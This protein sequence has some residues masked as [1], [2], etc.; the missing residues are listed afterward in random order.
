MLKLYRLAVAIL[1]SFLL[2]VN[3]G[4]H[5]APL[6]GS[7]RERRDVKAQLD[8]LEVQVHSGLAGRMQSLFPEGSAF[9]YALYGLA[10][11]SQARG[12]PGTARAEHAAREAE[13][14]LSRLDDP[15]VRGLFPT[16]MEPRYGAFY[17]GW[18]NYLLAHIVALADPRTPAALIEEFDERSAELKNAYMG[19]NTP[20][21]ASYDGMAWPADNV[22]AIASLAMHQRLRKD[23]GDDVIERWLRQA[24]ARL[25]GHG[26]VPHAWDPVH[27]RMVQASRGSSQSLMNCF[28]PMIDS[29]FSRDRFTRY[30]ERFL[31]T[32]LGVPMVRE[33]AEGSEGSGDVDSGPV[34]LGAGSSATIVGPGA[35]RMNGDIGHAQGLDASIEGFGVPF[36]PQQKRYVFGSLPIADLFIVWTR[37]L[38]EHRA[39]VTEYPSFMSFHLWSS[40]AVALLWL[41]LVISGLR[42]RRIATRQNA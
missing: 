12:S 6:I 20:F 16:V 5:R 1:S 3:V 21:L 29:A 7:D 9:T 28:F 40:L 41:P 35:F 13:W 32:R 38:S 8:Y 15:G 24:T 30:R 33:F 22:V 39:A 10:C 27:D 26:C 34:I 18:R 4:V 14:A 23:G 31:G 19:S 2:L 36:G 42:R 17:A 11:C 25:D 37:T